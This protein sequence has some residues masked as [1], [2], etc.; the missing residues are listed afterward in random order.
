[1]QE[2]IAR[3][4]RVFNAAPMAEGMGRCPART[5]GHVAATEESIFGITSKDG[6]VTMDIHL[7]RGC[8]GL[9]YTKTKKET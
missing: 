5:L 4:T 7:C 3:L 6:K 1:M 2:L 9:F 8:Q